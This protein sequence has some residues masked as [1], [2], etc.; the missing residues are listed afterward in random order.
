M[1]VQKGTMTHG[2]WE[3][4]EKEYV[5]KGLTNKIFLNKKFSCHR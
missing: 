4:F 2:I 1:I 5:N 3:A